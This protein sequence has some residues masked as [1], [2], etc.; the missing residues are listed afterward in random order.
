MN[1]LGLRLLASLEKEFAKNKASHYRGTARIRTS[2]L[3]FPDPL[4]PKDEKLVD[5]LKRDFRGEGCLQHERDCS[6]PAIISDDA[7]HQILTHLNITSEQLRQN[8]TTNPTLY[9]IPHSVTLNCLHGQHRILAASSYLPPGD[10][11]WL[12]DLFGPGIDERTRGLLREGHSYST[13]YSG[14]EIFRQIRL[15]QFNRDRIGEERW[16]ARLT[17]NQNQDLNKLLKRS[18]LVFSLDS[19]LP[20][21]GLWGD[22][23]MD[24]ILKTWTTI[25]GPDNNLMATLDQKTVKL[26][27]LRAPAVSKL[28]NEFIKNKFKSQDLF[29]GI[30][31]PNERRIIMDRILRIDILVPS[32]FTLFKDLRYLEPA[33][34]AIKGIFPAPDFK[35]KTL[36]EGL[37]FLFSDEIIA[38]TK[39]SVQQTEDT[40]TETTGSFDHTFDLAIRQ[41]FLCAMRYFTDPS[42][43]SSKKNMNPIQQTLNAPKRYLGF[44]LLNLS[45]R[46]NF[47]SL[48]QTSQ[49][50]IRELLIDILQTLPKEIFK[51]RSDPPADLINLFIQY[52][53]ESTATADVYTNPAITIGGE[54]GEPLSRRCGRA[55]ADISSKD[56]VHLFLEKMHRPLHEFQNDGLDVTS[57]FVKRC[58]YLAFF[59]DLA[60]ELSPQPPVE[61]QPPQSHK[62]STEPMPQQPEVPQ[63]P[64]Q[65][66]P[67]PEVSQSPRQN[68]NSAEPSLKQPPPSPE[69]SQSPRQN[70]NSAEPSLQQPPPPPKVPQPQKSPPPPEVLQPQRQN[71]PQNRLDEHEVQFLL[72]PFKNP[73]S[74]V[75]FDKEIVNKYAGRFANHGYSFMLEGVSFFTWDQCYEMLKYH[76]KR[77]VLVVGDPKLLKKVFP[78]RGSQLQLGEKK[79]KL[80]RNKLYNITNGPQPWHL[81]NE[82]LPHK[83]PIGKS[84]Q[85]GKNQ[86]ESQS[87]ENAMNK[88]RFSEETL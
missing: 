31:D 59:G 68:Q 66:P 64:Q 76:K 53:S 40:F 47:V 34:K 19:I 21:R 25:L 54:G 45:S 65:Q 37:R 10:R 71:H 18:L 44:K 6:V 49:D 72:A 23:H 14:G 3:L 1:S 7:Y 78:G 70:Q 8:S 27:E 86:E 83:N 12:V 36:R 60:I 13:N 29:P 77:R 48:L 26:M 41:L 5:T 56:R 16:R 74:T 80:G 43:I 50:P 2:Q 52:I 67:P 75:L 88:K 39:L 55:C 9:E 79:Q 4:R 62:T 81:E 15:C 57:F 84:S 61:P 46:L 58:I 24:L 28:D 35:K 17:V 30:F 63:P 82:E 38:T 42:N 11:W 87:D 33:A 20:L 32:I 73:T 85:E 22:F 51:L 69:V